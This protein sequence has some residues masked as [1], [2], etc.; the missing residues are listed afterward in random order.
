M[1]ADK[2]CYFAIMAV[3]LDFRVA[4]GAPGGA[5]GLCQHS[6]TLPLLLALLCAGGMEDHAEDLTALSTE[7]DRHEMLSEEEQHCPALAGSLV[8]DRTHFTICPLLPGISKSQS[9]V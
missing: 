4:R 3:T 6:S 7:V 1:A 8:V 9:L 2:E 5:V